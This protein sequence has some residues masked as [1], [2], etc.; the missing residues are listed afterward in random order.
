MMPY[1]KF[2]NKVPKFYQGYLKAF[3]LPFALLVL[4]GTLLI[5]VTEIQLIY[6]CKNEERNKLQRML[7]EMPDLEIHNPGLAKSQIEQILDLSKILNNKEAEAKG[8][9]WLSKVVGVEFKTS[10]NVVLAV[11][12]AQMSKDLINNFHNPFWETLITSQLALAYSHSGEIDSF[13]YY[14][15]QAYEISLAIKEVRKDSLYALAVLHKNKAVFIHQSSKKENGGEIDRNKF[16]DY[17]DVLLESF[18]SFK[19]IEDLDG[20]AINLRNLGIAYRQLDSIDQSILALKNALRINK[21]LNSLIAI[22]RTMSELSHS[23]IEKSRKTKSM[24]PFVKG[25]DYLN[26]AL[27]MG[28]EEKAHIQYR[29]GFSYHSAL[30]YFKDLPK[31]KF[32]NFLDSCAHYYNSSIKMAVKEKNLEILKLAVENYAGVCEDLKHPKSCKKVILQANE[33]YSKITKSTKRAQADAE[34]TIQDFKRETAIENEQK[35]RQDLWKIFGVLFL[36]SL[37]SFG[38]F[39]L[40]MRLNYLRNEFNSRLSALQ[41]QMNPHFISNSLNSIESLINLNQNREASKY[42][43]RFSHLARMVLNQSQNRAISLSNEIQLLT[44]YLEL[45]K[46]RMGEKL[47]FSIQVDGDLDPNKTLIPPMLIQPLVENA[48]WHG[49]KPKGGNGKVSIQFIK[50]TEKLLICTVEDD[51]VGRKRSNELKQESAYPKISHSTR[52]IQERIELLKQKKGAEFRIT[53]LTDEL[54]NATGTKAEM[55]IHFEEIS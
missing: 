55:F 46:L 15:D 34:L 29:K 45:E 5:L 23:F 24:E 22:Q 38:V 33:A 16:T 37:F 20:M 48:V 49:I 54:G 40:Q 13:G 6:K 28:L 31:E 14:L 50:E 42:L 32:D 1:S 53:D 27:S 44:N 4:I 17:K 2:N 8:Y 21:K 25:L 47:T 7:S 3:F 43:V 41:V 26:M 10:E 12:F 52:I 9:Y 35:R 51:G 11:K 19:E 39:S 30:A 36:L 18:E